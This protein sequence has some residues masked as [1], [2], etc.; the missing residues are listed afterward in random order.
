M[1]RKSDNDDVKVRTYRK[2]A[3]RLPDEMMIGLGHGKGLSPI[4][5]EVKRDGTLRLDIRDR[6]FNV[7]YR[8]GSLLCVDGRKKDWTMSFEQGFMRL[9][10]PD[11]AMNRAKELTLDQMRAQTGC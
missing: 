3:R 1:N 9:T 2:G 4:L 7:Y 6:R 5:D 11:Y 10:S 8:G